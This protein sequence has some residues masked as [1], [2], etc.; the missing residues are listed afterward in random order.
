M[1]R[2]AIQQRIL[3]ASSAAQAASAIGLSW[4]E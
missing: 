1:S 4:L 2:G 3:A